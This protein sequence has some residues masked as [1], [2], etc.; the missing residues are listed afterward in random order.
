MTGFSMDYA[1]ILLLPHLVLG[2][3]SLLYQVLGASKS[4]VLY[5]AIACLVVI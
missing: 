4:L 2:L 5:V 1:D 3:V